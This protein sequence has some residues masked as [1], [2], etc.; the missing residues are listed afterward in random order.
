MRS[1]IGFMTKRVMEPMSVMEPMTGVVNL[2]PRQQEE[3]PMTS[4]TTQQP[5]DDPLEA[6]RRRPS[7]PRRGIESFVR[8]VG[9]GEPVVF[10]HGMWGAPFCI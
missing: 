1:V 6:D 10:V 4:T 9:D 2:D 7:L 3:D 8:E 5:P